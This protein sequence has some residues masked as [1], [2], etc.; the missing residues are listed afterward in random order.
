MTR[1]FILSATMLLAGVSALFA[2]QDPDDPGIQDS[3]IFVC[4][5]DVIFPE[6]NYQ[7]CFLNIYAITDD[8][9]ACFSLPIRW[10]AISGGVYA[11]PGT[12]YLPPFHCSDQHYDTIISDQNYIRLF[13]CA[14]GESEECRP[15][16]T[17]GERALIAVVRLIIPPNPHSQLVVFDTTYDDR[18]GRVAFTDELGEVDITPGIQR[19]FLSIGTMAVDDER[20]VPDAFSLSQNYPNPFNASTAIK[21]SLPYAE[22]VRLDIYDLTGRNIKTLIDDNLETGQHSIIWDG[23]NYAGFSAPSGLYFYT[24]RT[25]DGALTR[26]MSMIK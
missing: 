9:I 14:T 18:L 21:F 7:I 5:P 13:A 6:N 20:I 23:V 1:I 2:Q 16:F 11:G 4:N 12:Q 25:D 3:L 15:L 22:H 8:S 26:K 19:G 24:L 10:D 17:D